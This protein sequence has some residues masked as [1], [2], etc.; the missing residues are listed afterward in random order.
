VPRRVAGVE[1][2]YED[3]SLLVVDKPAG[4][5]TH[6]FSGRETNS[7]ANHLLALRPELRKVGKSPW[8]PGLVHRLDRDTSGVVLVAKDED[9]FTNLRAQFRSESVQK[10]YWALVWGRT[11]PEG[12]IIYA[13]IHDPKDRR[14]MKG[15]TEAGRK[16]VKR[17][18][19]AATRY[20]TVAQRKG[21][22]LV[23]VGMIT[24][25]MHQIRAHFAA[26]GH[27][28]V[29]D[30]LYG[31]DR[32]LSLPVKR[33]FLHAACLRCRHPKSGAAMSWESPLPEDLREVLK[34]LEIEI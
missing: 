18:W 34:A 20:R 33:Q 7:L 28:L 11:R 27:P 24:G 32:R 21:L 3:P 31:N 9:S 1:I 10:K 5:P 15:V 17:A 30:L 14:K 12:R 2:I 13:L 29:G 23:E 8:E 16:R 6:G 4:M 26:I 19:A 25:V 22:S